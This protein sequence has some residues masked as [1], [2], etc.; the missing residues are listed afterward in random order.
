M[1][2]FQRKTL[3]IWKRIGETPLV[4]LGRLR[5]EQPHLADEKLSYAGRL[6]PMAEGKLLVLVGDMCRQRERY[7]GLD[8]TYEVRILFG[9][10]SDTGDVLGI[11]KNQPGELSGRLIDKKEVVEGLR[12][13]VGDISL[14]YP[15]YSSKTVD[16]KPLFEWALEGRLGDI[17]IPKRQ[18]HIYSARVKRVHTLDRATLLHYVQEKIAC[19]PHVE[20]VGK[21]LGRDFRRADVLAS[22]EE[23]IAVGP[24]AYSIADIVVRCSS[25]TYMRTLAVHL[26]K[27]LKTSALALAI[28]RTKIG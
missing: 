24:G 26:G 28:T 25:G 10:E 9:I 18:S 12:S 16:G 14:P 1:W 11:V 13:F 22:W 7:L 21:E 6:D 20:E 3:T 5:Q 8:K 19:L 23:A 15:A 27:Q 4:A 2:S 17:E